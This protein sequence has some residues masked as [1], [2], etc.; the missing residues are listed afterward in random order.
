MAGGRPTKY[1]PKYCNAVNDYIKTCVDYLDG[2]GKPVVG[3]PTYEGFLN[4]L[5]EQFGVVIVEKTLY[6]WEEENAE[7]LQS[8]DKIKR[9]QKIKLMQNGLAGNYNPTIAK[10][11]LSS[12]HGMSEKTQTDITSKGEAVN[13]YLPQKDNGMETS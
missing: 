13:F 10:L 1:D 6:N 2:N 4:Y 3:L 9:N 11:M 7:F 8:L 5:E 12:N